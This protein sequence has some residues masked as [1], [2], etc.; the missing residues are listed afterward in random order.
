MKIVRSL[1]AGAVAATLAGAL[2]AQAG[3][4]TTPRADF[5]L[6]FGA[7]KPG[8]PTTVR[9]RILY[10][11]SSA[12]AKPSPIRKIVIATPAGARYDTNALP[13]CG[14]SNDQLMAEGDAA[15]PPAS[16]LGGGQLTAITGFG[17]PID[18]FVGDSS[19]YNVDGG[20][21]E[22]VKERSSQRPLGTDRFQIK[23]SRWIGNPP[24][25]P[26]GPPDGETA[27]RR[28]DF[29]YAP[30][31]PWAI[32][33]PSCPS[34][35]RWRSTGTFTYADGVTVTVP[36]DTPCVRPATGHPRPRPRPDPGWHDSGR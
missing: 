9:L 18:P 21:A 23:G 3:A 31:A 7:T 16:R 19:I 12:D 30:K 6:D 29:T 33:P 32:T 15:C 4:G 27:V 2:A 35:R 20:F 22:I 26:G 1:L 14:A 5:T 36:D 10:K 28:I 8:A 24:T 17:P 13:R 34:D 25:T 11:G